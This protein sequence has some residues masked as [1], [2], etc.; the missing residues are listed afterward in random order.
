MDTIMGTPVFKVNRFSGT[1]L[2]DNIEMSIGTRVKQARKAAKLTQAEL[3][4][5]T[6]LKQ[7]SISDLEVGKSQGTTFI[8][9]LA[10]AL[11]VNPLWLETGKG[12]MT[13]A[14]LTVVQP[15]APA[16]S[17]DSPFIQDAKPV[18]VGDEPNTVAVRM[19][20][21]KLR[22]GA[23]GFEVEPDLMDGGEAHVPRSVVEQLGL[24]PIDLLAMRV[25]GQSMEPMM[26]EDDVIVI[27]TRDKQPN[28]R[29]LYAVNWNGEAL[30]K[31]LVRRNGD[32]YL[33][34]LNP[35]FEP[36]NVRSGQCSIVGRVVYQPGRVVTGRL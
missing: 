21:L 5:R 36:V 13:G 2:S 9:S 14:H 12:Q 19:V 22:A 11:G 1:S 32:W 23:T 35:D 34:S 3:A 28:S 7:S 26:F 17:N 15:D 4:S 24:H 29:E 25:R 10:A 18:R 30:I 20:T 16:F 31:M 33:H 8:A 6:G 27:N